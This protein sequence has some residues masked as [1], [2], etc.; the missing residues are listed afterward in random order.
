MTALARHTPKHIA[1][2][3]INY[4]PEEIGIARYT[5]DMARAL[6]RNGHTVDVLAGK[7]YYPAWEVPKAW[8][9]GGWRR[10]DE[11]GVHITRCPHYVPRSPNGL[12]RILHLMSFA[13]AALPPAL[14]MGRGLARRPGVRRHRPQVVRGASAAQLAGGMGGG[15]AV[16][17]AAVGAC[18]GF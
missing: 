17:R 12:R 10:G 7:P 2:V 6:V 8:R 15:A 18:A 1:V 5:T 16:A 14:R 11:H 4:A 3:G 9:G 13:A